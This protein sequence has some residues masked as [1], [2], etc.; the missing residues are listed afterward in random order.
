MADPADFGW[1]KLSDVDSRITHYK[2]IKFSVIKAEIFHW[3]ILG[4]EV[5]VRNYRGY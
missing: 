1:Q 3:E 4:F 2:L 5:F